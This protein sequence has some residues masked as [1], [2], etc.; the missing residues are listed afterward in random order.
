M[1]STFKITKD[2]EA[3]INSILSSFHGK[4][5]VKFYSEKFNVPE[6]VC[7]HYIKQKLAR[8]YSVKSKKYIPIMHKSCF[9]FSF[10]QYI[11]FILLIS[12]LSKKI[13]HQKRK[14]KLLIDDIQSSNEFNRWRC[15]EDKYTEEETVYITRFSTKEESSKSNVSSHRNLYDYDRVAV[16]S[17]GLKDLFTDILF[18]TKSSLWIK[19]NLFHIHTHF[20]NDFLYYGTLFKVCIADYMIQDRNLGRTNAL[21]NYL[22]KLSGGEVS[23]CIQKNIVQHNGNALFYDVDIFF[24]YGNRTS[25]D[26]MNLGA[27][28][29]KIHPIGSFAFNNSSNATESNIKINRIDVLYIGINAINSKK[30]DW[31]GYYE[32]VKWLAK[33][34]KKNQ[35]LNI[36]IKHHPSWNE[37]KK[38]I[39]IIKDS[40]IQY[41]N[42]NLDSY[43]AAKNSTFIV[44]YGSS[45]GYELIGYD[46]NVIFLDPINTNPF[47][48]NFVHDDKN[49]INDYMNMELLLGDIEK[50]K[51]KKKSLMLSDY[52]HQNKTISDSIYQALDSYK[53]LNQQ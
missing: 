3:D 36:Y 13:G 49:V 11:I 51:E 24:A 43:L 42:K 46:F 21:K 25:E 22:F 19:F 35:H 41:L 33:F 29:D 8:S 17:L 6:E 26:I 44:T 53:S 38:E 32:S 1:N 18:L 23:S 52:C 31:S 28:I 45:M 9:F 48:N 16:L 7:S 4:R 27:R 10:L 14:F 30:T 2:L 39:K 20:V 47:I 40:G 15:L 12:L 34:S 37:D 50:Y 5:L